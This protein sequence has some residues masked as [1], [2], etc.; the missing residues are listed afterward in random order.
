MRWKVP[1]SSPE[2]DRKAGKSFA[3]PS[4]MEE[5]CRNDNSSV[6]KCSREK[7]KKDLGSL[8]GR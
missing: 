4:V 8:E 3:N 6:Q 5:L 2:L 7:W 1:A